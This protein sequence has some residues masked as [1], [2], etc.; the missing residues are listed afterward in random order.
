M[1]YALFVILNEVDYLD[2][3]LAGFAKTGV[4]GATILDSQGMASAILSGRNRSIPLFGS[5]KTLLGEAR[6]YSKT[7]FSVLEN[8]ET[9][10]IVAEMIRNVIRSAPSPGAAFIF[11]VPI[12]KIYPI[13]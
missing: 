4:S 10:D 1:P 11:S 9:A 5:L 2:D 12:G 3:I 6:P 8:E 13:R 7:I